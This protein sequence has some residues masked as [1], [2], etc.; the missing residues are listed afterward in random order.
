MYIIDAYNFLYKHGEYR[1]NDAFIEH[2][3]KWCAHYKRRCILVFDGKWNYQGEDDTEY[4][5]IYYEHDADAMIKEL[6][7]ECQ[8]CKLV[9]SDVDIQKHARQFKVKIFESADFVFDIPEVEDGSQEE[10]YISQ[11]EVDEWLEVFKDS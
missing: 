2:V 11:N 9:T 5:E 4:L 3:Q 1:D 10:F 8:P 6:V 7:V